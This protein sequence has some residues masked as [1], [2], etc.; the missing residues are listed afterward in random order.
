MFTVRMPTDL[1]LLS[2]SSTW[3]TSTG[4]PGSEVTWSK[5]S[6]SASTPPELSK[7][8]LSSWRWS[9]GSSATHVLRSSDGS[10]DVPVRLRRAHKYAEFHSNAHPALRDLLKEP[11]RNRSIEARAPPRHPKHG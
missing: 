7:R 4:R 8:C 6:S 1:R 11:P 5:S 10:P 9:P 3:R 2:A